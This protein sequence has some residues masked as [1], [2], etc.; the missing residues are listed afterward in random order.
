MSTPV[1]GY[2]LGPAY[3]SNVDSLR[4]EPI[5][6]LTTEQSEARE[7]LTQL[8]LA[9]GDLE[10]DLNLCLMLIAKEERKCTHPVFNDK[11]AYPYWNRSC[12]I[13]GTHLDTI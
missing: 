5:A 10:R 7:R 6:S 13:C 1:V 9:K 2:T 12:E 8:R 4:P 11:D 3:P